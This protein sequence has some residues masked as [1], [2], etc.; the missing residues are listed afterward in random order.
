MLSILISLKNYGLEIIV[1]VCLAFMTKNF[2]KFQQ[3]LSMKQ[4]GVGATNIIKN[5]VNMGWTFSF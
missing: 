4:T 2:Q 3:M 1:G 5:S